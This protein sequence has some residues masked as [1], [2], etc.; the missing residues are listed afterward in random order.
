MTLGDARARLARRQ[1]Q[2]VAALVAGGEVPEGF[3]ARRLRVQA[4]S[5]IA[6]RRGVVARLR[7]DAAAAAYPD[8]VELFAAYAAERT[9]PP[10]SYR[11]DANDFADWLRRQGRM[12]SDVRE[13]WWRR[14]VRA[15]R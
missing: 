10:P 4:R 2:V 9:E 12:R 8:L 15:R 6:K 5:L 3:D 1:E 11:A 7:P 14:L 13:P